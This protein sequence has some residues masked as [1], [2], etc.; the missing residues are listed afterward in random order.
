MATHLLYVVHMTPVDRRKGQRR[1]VSRGGRRLE[2][3]VPVRRCPCEAGDMCVGE[4]NHFEWRQCKACG[5]VWPT[6]CAS[7]FAPLYVHQ[8]SPF[9]PLG[10]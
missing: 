6:L 1:A 2:D 3:W 8:G 10:H 7:A 5:S 4:G 9:D